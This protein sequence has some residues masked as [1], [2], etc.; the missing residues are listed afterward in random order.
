M[1]VVTL[2]ILVSIVI[3]IPYSISQINCPARNTNGC[4]CGYKSIGCNSDYAGDE[5]PNFIKS[6]E[7]FT[8]VSSYL[9]MYRLHYIL[10]YYILLYY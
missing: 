6:N 3:L 8:S 7:L 10:I 2:S 5:I 9:V 1:N 4:Y